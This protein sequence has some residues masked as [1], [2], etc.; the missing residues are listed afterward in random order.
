MFART[1]ALLGEHI[2]LYNICSKMHNGSRRIPF[3]SDCCILNSGDWWAIAYSLNGTTGGNT[4]TVYVLPRL[5]VRV[6]WSTTNPWRLVL[7]AYSQWRPCRTCRLKYHELLTTCALRHS[8]WRPCRTCRGSI[9]YSWRL[10]LSGIVNGGPA[11]RIEGV[12]RTLDD[13]CSPA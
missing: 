7:M 11:G 13:L 8:Q 10:V 3:S 4:I 5:A 6:G 12:S 1:F 9:T 2:Y